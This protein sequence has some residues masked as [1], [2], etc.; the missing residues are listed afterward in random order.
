MATSATYPA[1]AFSARRRWHS[2]ASSGLLQ[3]ASVDQAARGQKLTND[4]E[5]NGD[6][7]Y[8]GIAGRNFERS[9]QLAEHVEVKGAS[10][11]NGLLHVD[12]AR[13]V[14]EAMK[15]RAIPIASSRKV[16]EVKPTQAAA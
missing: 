2:N 13:E 10:L 8:R 9:F 14:P 7:L 4:E 11:E 16:L 3:L 6:L 5:K 12:L 1:V 15:S